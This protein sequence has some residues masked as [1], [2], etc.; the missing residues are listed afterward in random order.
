MRKDVEVLRI[1]SAFGIVWFHSGVDFGRDVSYAGLI[2]FI[3]TSAYFTMASTRETT[4]FDRVSRLLIPCIA[5]ALFYALIKLVRGVAVFPDDFSFIEMLLV[6][7]SVHLWYLPFIFFSLVIIDVFKKHFTPASMGVVAG[8]LAIALTF[9]APIWKSIDIATPGGE[10]FNG[11]PVVLMG[12]FLACYEK[13]HALTRLVILIM[14]MVSVMWMALNGIGIA[15]IVGLTPCLLFLKKDALASQKLKWIAPI[16]SATFG[17]Y[18]VHGFTLFVF[19]HVGINGII[20]PVGAFFVSLFGIMIARK[21]LPAIIV[22][23]TL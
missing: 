20:L 10:Y 15:Y 13:I 16:S 18:L 19:L 4:I 17:V 8:M 21:I 7:P 1:V 22:K 6:T 3:I 12:V 9:A 2:Y 11:I 23:Y 5:W 14:V